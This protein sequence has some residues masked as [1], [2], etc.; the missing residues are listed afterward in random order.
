MFYRQGVDKRLVA[1]NATQLTSDQDI[2]WAGSL[3]ACGI[4]EG[5][6]NRGLSD[7]EEVI[8]AGRI[9]GDDGSG[10][11]GGGRLG[12]LHE[13]TIQT[14][15]GSHPDVA[16]AAGDDRVGGVSQSWWEIEIH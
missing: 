10:V 1:D 4:S 7:H 13:G 5:V 12:P 6:G 8:G 16:G 11:V 9:G 14:G 2:E 3:V 15:V